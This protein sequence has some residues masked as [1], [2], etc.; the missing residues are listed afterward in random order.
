MRWSFILPFTNLGTNIV[1]T[2]SY[3]LVG[4]HELMNVAV[5]SFQLEV[6]EMYK[7]NKKYRKLKAKPA[8]T[9]TNQALQKAKVTACFYA[10]RIS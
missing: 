3:K 6:P 10:T 9:S 5:I 8:G 1:S 4:T 2:N 7:L